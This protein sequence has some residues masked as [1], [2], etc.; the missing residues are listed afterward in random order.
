MR[1]GALLILKK[2]GSKIGLRP[3][4]LPNQHWQIHH[5]RIMSVIREDISACPLSC[6]CCCLPPEQH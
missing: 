4:L 5:V 3:L 2:A 1:G 6:M